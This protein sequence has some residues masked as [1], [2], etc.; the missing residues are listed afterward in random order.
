MNDTDLY[1]RVIDAALALLL[2]PEQLAIISEGV[3]NAKD[4]RQVLQSVVSKGIG[5]IESNDPRV[6][7]RLRAFRQNLKDNAA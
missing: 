6:A 4:R 3:G 1:D 5:F 7:A 2:T